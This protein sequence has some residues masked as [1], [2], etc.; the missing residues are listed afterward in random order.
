MPITYDTAPAT[1]HERIA[2]LVRANH[3]DLLEA[4]VTF[5]VQMVYAARDKHGMPKGH[6][7]KYGG[8]AA[9]ALASVVPYPWRQKGMPDVRIR[10]DGDWWKDAPEAEQESTLDHELQH[11]MVLRDKHGSIKSDDLGRPKI[12]LRPHDWLMGGFDVIM[13]RHKEHAL[14]TQFAATVSRKLVQMNLPFG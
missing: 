10:I 2:A 6:A 11:C 12:K 7:L 13:E 3:P 1:I 14:E 5:W 9:V 4:Q 8:S